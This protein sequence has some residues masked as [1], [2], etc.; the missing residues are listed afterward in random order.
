MKLEFFIAK[1]ILFDKTAKHA[2]TRPIINIAVWGIA[3]GVLIMIMAV[4]MTKGFQKEIKGKIVELLPLKSGQSA[5]GEWRKQE[6]VLETDANYPKKICF[7][8]WGDK[9]DQFN[10]NMGDQ[11]EVSIDLESREYN[12][13]WYTDVKAWKVSKDGLGADG[14]G[15]SDNQDGYPPAQSGSGSFEDDEIPF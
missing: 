1:R 14:P 5:N 12:G 4:S 3:L 9:I 7:M 2:F 11:V 10:I 13:R 15:R 6:Y 8:A